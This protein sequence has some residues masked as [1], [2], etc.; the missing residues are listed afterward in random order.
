MF[1]VNADTGNESPSILFTGSMMSLTILTVA[2]R[3]DNSG[4]GASVSGL[5]QDAGISTL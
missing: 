2:G 5:A 3:P 4:F 1:P